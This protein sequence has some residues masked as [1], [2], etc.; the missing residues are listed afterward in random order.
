M[1]KRQRTIDEKEEDENEEED[2]DGFETNSR[3]AKQRVTGRENGG[4]LE[5][6][7]GS[8]PPPPQFVANDLQDSATIAKSSN[9]ARANASEHQG[10]VGA[11]A[12]SRGFVPPPP[13]PVVNGRRSPASRSK[14]ANGAE[15]NHSEH[16]QAAGARNS[17]DIGALEAIEV[18]VKARET[19]LKYRS[20][21]KKPQNR[22][23]WT[24][25]DVAKLIAAI[26]KHG[27]SW[28]MLE[29]ELETLSTPRNQQQIRDKARNIKVDFLLGDIP[30]PHGFDGIALGKKEKEK[31]ISC[32]RNPDR[33][34]ADVDEN[35]NAINCS[36][37]R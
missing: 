27:C 10:A 18:S 33:E 1:L 32:E 24:A 25:G 16:N 23:P 19:A 15:D 34:E 7:P 6:S 31:V 21:T 28:S 30:L 2:E 11:A 20:V 17:G 13:E 14:P 35:G 22:S 5:S 37:S 29:N 3:P 12:Q 36:Y 8:V 4:K 9:G 26:S